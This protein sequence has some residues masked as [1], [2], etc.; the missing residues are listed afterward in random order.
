MISPEAADFLSPQAVKQVRYTTITSPI[1]DLMI[2]GDGEVVTNL[3]ME[4]HDDT[5]P[6]I[7]SDWKRD[8]SAFAEVRVQ[9]HEYFGGERDEFSVP[10]APSGTAFRMK[11][12]ATLVRIPFGATATYG[13]VAAS[14]GN[15]AASRAVGMANHYN[16]IAIMIPCHRV[17]G[18]SGS[19]TGY[20]GGLDRKTFLL[21]LEQ[22][23][24]GSGSSS[25][26]QG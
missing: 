22:T 13:E 17:I 5:K 11:V 18:A 2:V 19:L 25:A 1:G 15:P 24:A 10:L 26:T 9:L 23:R 20:G 8:S 21:G 12:W 16:P 3:S 14:I 6:T 7:E 4:S